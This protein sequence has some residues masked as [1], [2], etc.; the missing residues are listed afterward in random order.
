MLAF[1]PPHYELLSSGGHVMKD[2]STNKV[3]AIRDATF[4]SYEVHLSPNAWKNKACTIDGCLT[5]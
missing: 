3:F 4:S 2:Q 5:I 1:L